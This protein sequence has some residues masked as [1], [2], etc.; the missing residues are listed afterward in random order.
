[1][2]NKADKSNDNDRNFLNFSERL[3]KNFKVRNT[4]CSGNVPVA[5]NRSRPNLN[6]IAGPSQESSWDFGITWAQKWGCKM[7]ATKLGNLLTKWLN[8]GLS[9]WHH[10]QFP[11]MA[12]EAKNYKFGMFCQYCHPFVTPGDGEIR[13]R[14]ASRIHTCHLFTL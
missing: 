2:K 5:F 10:N 11:G 6:W 4:A 3:S 8:F 7:A 12:M 14:N 1:M 9:L 13:L